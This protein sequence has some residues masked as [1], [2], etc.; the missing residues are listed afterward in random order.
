MLK[1][2]ISWLAAAFVAVTLVSA[3]ADDKSEPANPV[4]PYNPTE[5]PSEQPSAAGYTIGEISTVFGLNDSFSEILT[6]IIIFFII[7]CEFFIQ[8]TVKFRHAKKEGKAE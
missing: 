2:N 1:S 5:K 3:C 6:G 4:S 7:G 8:Y